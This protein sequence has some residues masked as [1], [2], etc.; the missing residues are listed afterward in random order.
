MNK[1]CILVAYLYQ[2]PQVP[3]DAKSSCF[4]LLF[5]FVWVGRGYRDSIVIHKT[6]VTIVY[7]VF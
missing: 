3:V 6:H 7:M 2:A 4:L 1:S 5:Y